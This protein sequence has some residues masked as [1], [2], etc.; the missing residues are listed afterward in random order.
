VTPDSP[1]S[2]IPFL[3]PRPARLSRL[4][5]ELIAIEA[6]GVYSNYGPVNARFEAAL[7]Q[8]M[9]GG[10]GGCVT[11]NNA[12][13]G[14][15]LAIREAMT[16]GDGRHYA[17]MP[18]FTFAAAGHAALWAG[19]TPL[20][21]DIDPETWNASPESELWLL[22]KY[23][24][25]VACIVPY[26]CLGNCIDLE[27]YERLAHDHGVGIVVDGAASLGSIDETDQGF[28]TG[29]R[30]AVVYSMHVTKAFATGE[31]GVIYCNDSE[32]LSRLRA[33]GNF[34]FGRPREATMPG[35]NAKL[36]EIGA[37]LALTK[38]EE[39]DNVVSHR[40]ELAEVYRQRLVGFQFQRVVGRRLAYQFMPVLL[41]PG[42][43]VSRA[44]I[45]SALR[46]EGI[47]VGHYFS[48]HL[49]EQ[50]FFAETCMA[51]NLAVTDQVAG[52]VLSLPMSDE[53][54]QAEAS[55]VADA[56]LQYS[57]CVL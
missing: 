34:G 52:R 23:A 48:P 54:A 53:M 30:H 8:Q 37:L 11:V 38:L 41:P 36:S 21:C 2:K 42:C 1:A 18:S 3:R 43:P 32:R 14:L 4:T 31:A 44:D 55:T 26:A 56:L 49:F 7:T 45:V 29:F 19:L 6:S 39:F 5:G 20:L 9:F 13:T 25:Q 24:G 50:S 40:H 47:G 10:T 17:L 27:Y 51:G 15:M 22:R 57:G 46:C 16:P 28:G 33:M 12:T 35:L